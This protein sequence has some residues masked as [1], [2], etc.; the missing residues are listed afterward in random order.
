[1][2]RHVIDS[3][4]PSANLQRRVFLLSAA[5][6]VGLLVARR[7]A[8]SATGAATATP[9]GGS[10]LEQAAKRGELCSP[11]NAIGVGLRGEYFGA[12]NCLGT[13]LLTRIDQVVDFDRSLDWPTDK[14]AQPPRSVRWSGWIKPPLGGKYRFHC[15]VPGARMLVSRTPQLGGNA[16]ADTAI[17]LA[18]GRYFPVVLEIPRLA[19][20]TGRIRLEWTAPFGSRYVIPRQLLHL[21]TDTVAA[22]A[23]S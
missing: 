13:A 23:K 15:D 2:D 10:E 7:D 17:E 9:A 22:P 19:D 1:M 8:V 4:R 3:T 5:G 11:S 6:T 20:V 21:P 12:E 16:P 18:A 14:R